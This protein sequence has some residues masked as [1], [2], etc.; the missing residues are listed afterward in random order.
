M[1]LYPSLSTLTD[2]GSSSTTT[3]LCL[4][5]DI[6]STLEHLL[7]MYVFKC[8]AWCIYKYMNKYIFHRCKND[9]DIEINFIFKHIDSYI[10]ITVDPQRVS[11]VTDSPKIVSIAEIANMEG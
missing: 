3:G 1:E 7:S 10:C 11:L 9:I 5:F 8:T 4:I 6:L 2:K